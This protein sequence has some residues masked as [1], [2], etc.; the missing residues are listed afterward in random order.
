M[1]FNLFSEQEFKPPKN[2][3]NFI[4]KKLHSKGIGALLKTT[5]VFSSDDEKKLWDTNVLNL[6]TPIGLLRA[7]FFY[8]GKNFCLRGGAEQCNLKLSQFQTEVTIVEG[9]EVGCYYL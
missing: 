9:Q 4:F 8:N 6:E 1:Q 7:V 5:A 2:L 3:C